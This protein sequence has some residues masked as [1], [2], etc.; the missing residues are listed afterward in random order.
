M[1]LENITV[2]I[3]PRSQWEAFDIG[4]QLARKWYFTLLYLW[5]LA[6]FPYFVLI[7]GVSFLLPGKMFSWSLLLFWFLKPLYEP[8]ML[9]WI[10]KVLFGEQAAGR[11]TLKKMRKELNL[12]SFFSILLLRFSLFRS[13]TL[14]VL[15][16]EKARG[17]EKR[18]RLSLL[19]QDADI[20]VVLTFLGSCIELVLMF[21]LMMF[22]FWLIPEELRWVNFEGF[23]F[24]PDNWL[25][26]LSY[27]LACALFA[28]FYVSSGFMLYISRRVTLEA[29]DIEIGFKR[30]RQNIESRRNG[31]IKMVVLLL[32][33]IS[34]VGNSWPHRC[35]ASDMDPA[36]A[37]EAIA[38]VLA[39][40]EFGKTVTKTRWVPKER[41]EKELDSDFFRYLADILKKISDFIEN[42]NPFIAFTGKALVL[43]VLGGSILFL[44]LR[45]TQL[46]GW[47]DNYLHPRQSGY[48]PPEIMFGMD[49]RPESLPE[50][51]GATCE[52]LLKEGNKRGALSLLY[53]GTL[54]K[55]ITFEKLEIN[56]SY[57]ENECCLE[58]RKSRPAKESGFFDE[59]TIRWVILAYGHRQPED[60]VCH[61]LLDTWRDLYGARAS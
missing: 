24:T 58:V 14:P 47:L 21:S 40:E 53:R 16:L 55:L 43:M 39:S 27:I 29:W 8:P 46:R 32:L 36:T 26:F 38:E 59:L 61:T 10:S 56:S 54:S 35:Q 30:M 31:L 48:T 49:L 4:F 6:A 60:G 51:I 20:C 15:I 1:N 42:L 12:R 37:K 34:L 45:F 3:R 9:G 13:F 28:P 22:L 52:R 2:N 17:R 57:T 23:V 41:E 44:I 11:E 25:M 18:A 7:L 5:F 33:S 50:D 19:R